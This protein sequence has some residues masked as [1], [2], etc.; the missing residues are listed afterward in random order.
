[1]TNMLPRCA[2]E[3]SYRDEGLAD[4]GGTRNEA[5]HGRGRK[6]L[7]EV[8][9]HPARRKTNTMDYAIQLFD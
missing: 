3:L 7:V 8:S 4:M 2:A 6:R 9:P 5:Q 1:M